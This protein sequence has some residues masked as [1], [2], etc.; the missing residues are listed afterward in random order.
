MKIDFDQTE[1]ARSRPHQHKAMI[2]YVTQSNF[3]T[4]SQMYQSA[5]VARVRFGLA[6]RIRVCH[7]GALVFHVIIEDD[8][9][10]IQIVTVA[11]I[12]LKENRFIERPH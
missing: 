1:K 12:D 6:V 11:V 7:C 10:S 8:F 5:C 4:T 3:I 9:I 2:A